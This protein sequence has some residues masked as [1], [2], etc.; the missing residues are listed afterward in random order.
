MKYA[1]YKI[2]K[3]TRDWQSFVIQISVELFD[4]I[5][6]SGIL[7]WEPILTE[8]KKSIVPDEGATEFQWER[9]WSKRTAWAF[10]YMKDKEKTSKLA[11]SRTKRAVGIRKKGKVSPWNNRVVSKRW[12]WRASW[13]R[14]WRNRA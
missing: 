8:P 6:R 2:I 10:W 9:A 13:S 12:P 7:P 5:I 14:G 1:P 3:K 4:E 11:T